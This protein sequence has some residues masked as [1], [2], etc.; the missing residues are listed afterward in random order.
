MTQTA[1]SLTMDV[2]KHHERK[3]SV[4]HYLH[5]SIEERESI[6]EKLAQGKTIRCIAREL[7]RSAST[8]SRELHR[9]KKPQGKYWPSKAQAADKQRRKRCRRKQLLANEE[10]VRLVQHLWL[11][12]HWSPEQI[13][14]R[15]RLEG[16]RLQ[17]SHAT[18]YRGIRAHRLEIKK[19]SHNER[20]VILR[21]RMKGRKG[22]KKE[23]NGR[24]RMAKAG[25]ITQRPDAAN[26]R[27]EIGH[28]EG[29]T[30]LGILNSGRLVTMVDRATRYALVRKVESGA[31]EE[32]GQAMLR[33]LEGVPPQAR[34]SVTPDLGKEFYGYKTVEE[35]MKVR[36]YFP[37]PS[38]PW[39]RPT[40]ENF[41]GLLREF[42]PKRK[43]FK[44]LTQTEV[45]Q[46][47]CLINLRPRK[48]LGWKSPFE[49]F[50]N[51]LLHLT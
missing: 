40:N 15:L 8:I 47:V 4:G 20:G 41:N 35:A 11:D 13:S 44:G 42:F 28:W 45:D 39:E 36:F 7:G 18:I 6:L 30:V 46:A 38:S 26:E 34:K 32:V 43:S 37:H 49:V 22:K 19:L 29:D 9:N 5:L 25:S 48:C 3:S 50:F 10:L 23:K 21:L 33:L 27:T 2:A 31:A 1:K 24:G 16:N 51:N 14:Q 17:I 12:Y